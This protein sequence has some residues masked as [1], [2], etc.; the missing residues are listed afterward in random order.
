MINNVLHLAKPIKLVI[1]DVDGVLTDGSLYLTDKNV[2]IKAFHCH[3]GLGIKF[4]LE[5]GIKIAV[6]SARQAELVIHRMKSLGINYIYQGDMNKITAYEDLMQKTNLQDNEIAFVGDDVLDVP[7]I[8]RANLGIAV[9]N[10]HPFAQQHADWVTTIPGGQG[11]VREVCEL[12]M[13]AQGKL[14]D[15]YNR[16]L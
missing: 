10:A 14:N 3:D 13:K 1:F 12:I 2:E 6:I 7:L 5:T 11:A 4:L 15:I 9:K 8:R 16:Y